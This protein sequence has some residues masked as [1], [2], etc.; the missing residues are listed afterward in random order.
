MKLSHLSRLAIGTTCYLLFLLVLAGCFSPLQEKRRN[1]ACKALYEWIQTDW[2]R[3]PSANIY[4]MA[5]HS[6]RNLEHEIIARQECF[7]GLPR[8]DIERLLG[9]PDTLV[10]G[11]LVYYLGTLCNEKNGLRTLGCLYLE[12]ALASDGTVKG[13]AAVQ[14]GYKD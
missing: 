4:R 2:S 11:N 6:G 10:R 13:V 3:D 1:P 12:C 9:E 7:K 5:S 14:D 8:R